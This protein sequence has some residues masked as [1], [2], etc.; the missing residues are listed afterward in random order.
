MA[1]HEEY[2]QTIVATTARLKALTV[3]AI[4]ALRS[5]A[6]GLPGGTVSGPVEVTTRIPQSARDGVVGTSVNLFLFRDSVLTLSDISGASQTLSTQLHYLVT[7][8]PAREADP[9]LVVQLLHG[10]ICSAVEANPRHGLVLRGGERWEATLTVDDPPL[11]DL[12]A[13]WLTSG[14]P[15]RLSAVIVVRLVPEAHAA[16]PLPPPS[17]AEVVEQ[18]RPGLVVVFAGRDAAAKAAAAV[19]VAHQLG[20]SVLRVK[21]D[22]LVSKYSAETE[23]NLKRVMASGGPRS[24]P[25]VLLFDEADALFGKRTDVSDAHNRYEGVEINDVVDQLAAAPSIVIIPVDEPGEAVLKRAGI[26]LRF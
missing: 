18:A 14:A 19:E 2:G 23:Q 7:G 22:R 24:A 8:Y 4:A 11:S 26:V 15:F 20:Q 13:L 5:A 16:S 1:T 9:E 12:T 10:A 17:V 3:T 21:P 6:D 25:R